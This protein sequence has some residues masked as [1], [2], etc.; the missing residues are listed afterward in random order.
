MKCNKC[1]QDINK[2]SVKHHSNGTV[3]ISCPLCNDEIDNKDVIK[4]MKE[5]DRLAKGAGII[6]IGLIILLLF[7]K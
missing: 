4:Y 2:L 3:S 6:V 7:L 1:K 5:Q